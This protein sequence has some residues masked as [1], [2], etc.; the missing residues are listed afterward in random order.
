MWAVLSQTDDPQTHPQAVAIMYCHH[1]KHFWEYHG[2]S[3]YWITC[4]QCLGKLKVP[5]NQG[6]KLPA[7][8]WLVVAILLFSL[9]LPTIVSARPDGFENWVNTTLPDVEEITLKPEPVVRF[10]L[11]EFSTDL[12]KQAGQRLGLLPM[13]DPTI[14]VVINEA[15]VAVIPEDSKF[16]GIVPTEGC[17]VYQYGTDGWFDCEQRSLV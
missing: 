17:L 14:A 9:V 15:V 5:Q 1:C 2:R 10:E 4:P 12:L 6:G 8:K 11:L 3:Q 7:Y 16:V 13:D